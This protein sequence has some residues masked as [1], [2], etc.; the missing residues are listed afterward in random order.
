MPFYEKSKKRFRVS[1]L[2]S[3]SSALEGIVHTLKL[4]RNMRIHFCAGFLVVILGVYL[5]LIAVEF[6][7]LCF[8][9][10]LVL[11]SEMFNTVVEHA[12]DFFNK[13]FH[14]KIKIIKDISAGAVFVSSINAAIV[15]YILLVK[16]VGVSI[17]SA[18]SII[19]QSSW[20]S[21]VISLLVVIG[22]VLFVKITRKE[23]NLLR[24]G[25]P[26]GHSAVAFAVWMVISLIVSDPLISLLVFFLG[27]LIARSRIVTG[28]HNVVEVI[29]GGVI[30]ALSSLLIFQLLT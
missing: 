10:T 3:I 25:M 7:F 2:G 14:P 19:K 12:F 17:N 29:A 9:V 20:H 13:E 5:N 8:A 30:G 26:S 28:A 21:T 4:E 15:G 18:F 16:R 22:I 23:K 11:V 1:F 24:G 6:M 27:V